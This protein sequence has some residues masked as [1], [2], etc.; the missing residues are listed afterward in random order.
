MAGTFDDFL[1]ARI[2]R[3]AQEKLAAAGDLSESLT[4][5]LLSEEAFDQRQDELSEDLISTRDE[6]SEHYDEITSAD[7][8]QDMRLDENMSEKDKKKA[9][10]EALER[11]KK[12]RKKYGAS[13]TDQTEGLI[14][15]IK[16]RK[17]L[18][19]RG[20]AEHVEQ[21]RDRASDEYLHETASEEDLVLL[22]KFSNLKIPEDI[23]D[24]TL[25]RKHEHFDV[26]KCMLIKECLDQIA[27]YR[28][29]QP[30]AYAKLDIELYTKLEDLYSMREAFTRTLDATL[31]ANG[32]DAEGNLIDEET[33]IEAE[34]EIADDYKGAFKDML[35]SISS[36]ERTEKI[37][38]EKSKR[39]E[40][41]RLVDTFY[42][43][44]ETI[45]EQAIARF[46]ATDL[47]EPDEIPWI[48]NEEF[49]SE[50]MY[51]IDESM[52]EEEQNAVV[53]ERYYCDLIH[54]VKH[55]IEDPDA[56]EAKKTKD[57]YFEKAAST[58]TQKCSDF[59][60]ELLPLI[61]KIAYL[62][63]MQMM[64][65]YEQVTRLDLSGRRSYQLA[66]ATKNSEGKSVADLLGLDEKKKIQIERGIEYLSVIRERLASFAIVK[67]EGV[68][69][70]LEYFDAEGNRDRKLSPEMKPFISQHLSNGPRFEYY[71]DEE[72]RRE[73]LRDFVGGSRSADR[74]V[75][76]AGF[77][78]G[79][80]KALKRMD[81]HDEE[82]AAKYEELRE[83]YGEVEANYRFE[84]ELVK[85]GDSLSGYRTVFENGFFIE[86]QISAY[87]EVEKKYEKL[88]ELAFRDKEKEDRR[89]SRD[90]NATRT[91]LIRL[92]DAAPADVRDYSEPE[93]EEKVSEVTE[94][95][96]KTLERV[97]S[98]RH[99]PISYHDLFNM[100]YEYSL[101][102]R[103]ISEIERDCFSSSKVMEK[104]DQE[105]LKKLLAYKEYAVKLGLFQRI[106]DVKK[107]D[108]FADTLRQYGGKVDIL[109]EVNEERFD[110]RLSELA[111]KTAAAQAHE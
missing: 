108:V 37:E 18:D 48:F 93:L 14:S 22:R 45:A 34:R 96:D 46:R 106:H 71:N 84:G 9:Q 85:G 4:V 110:Q 39:K 101:E 67:S 42:T 44:K 98:M 60:D 25:D 64:D 80:L 78:A 79:R 51:R 90:R 49:K 87:Y 27:K 15:S 38:A 35:R 36:V 13:A 40:Q 26:K 74:G 65:Y 61:D 103:Q 72:L 6:L 104:I 66:K 75:R 95:M 20:K 24:L 88:S 30:A 69:M 91:S 82:M 41:A 63:E 10:E 89:F 2:E 5:S 100:A 21:F 17:K 47:P 83:K 55:E 7:T 52:S 57:R 29:T 102:Y 111:E 99:E 32:V 58:L 68:S 54:K 107:F 70:D 94:R 3:N 86:Q 12:A 50:I 23:F 56:E 76:Y 77:T 53:R 11:K 105:K 33:D 97:E 81:R 62:P 8:Y 109:P 1:Q 19:A 31:R 43:E 92:K 59:I 73:A 16:R 28:D